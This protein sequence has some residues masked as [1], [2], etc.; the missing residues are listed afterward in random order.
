MQRREVLRTLG[1]LA[2]GPLVAPLSATDRL[3]LGAR[4]HGRLR[5]PRDLRVLSPAQAALTAALADTLLPRTDT[6]GALDAGAVE[7]FDLLLDEWHTDEE[8]MALLAGLDQFDERCLGATG[9]RYAEAPVAS[10]EAFLATVDGAEGPAGSAEAAWARLRQVTI[11]AWGTSKPVLEG[12]LQTPI[13]PGRF[14]GCVP[15]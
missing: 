4:L 5:V 2:L 11:F 12:P 13:I 6:P 8:R 15:V 10:R 14:D 9:A 7:F 3:A 1:A